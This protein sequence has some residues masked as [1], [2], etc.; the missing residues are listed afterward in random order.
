[1][2]H[3][4]KSQIA[5]KSM[6]VQQNARMAELEEANAQLRAELNAAQSRMAEVER[7]E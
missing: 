5:K 1:V 6:V 7:R 4:T 3:V 2:L